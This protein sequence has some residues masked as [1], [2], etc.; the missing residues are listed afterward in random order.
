MKQDSGPKAPEAVLIPPSECVAVCVKA[1]S[2]K[3]YGEMRCVLT[4]EIMA[5]DKNAGARIE[6][7]SVM[8]DKQGRVKL[9]G[10][11]YASWCLANGGR[12]SRNAKMSPRVFLKKAFR[13]QVETA[14]E[15]ESE[16]R[17]YSVVR[18]IKEL[19]AGGGS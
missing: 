14:N 4:F 10:K 5:P 9:G 13:V 19:V 16:Y 17:H 18:E 3:I 12:P 8:C 1:V 6:W 15:N 7:F 11:Y 2:R